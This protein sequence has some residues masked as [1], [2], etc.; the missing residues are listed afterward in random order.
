MLKR[1]YCSKWR[2]RTEGKEKKRKGKEGKKEDKKM[3]EQKMR[4]DEKIIE[5]REKSCGHRKNMIV[6]VR[7]MRKRS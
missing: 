1:V 5:E 7:K 3:R 2:D 4:A 6:K